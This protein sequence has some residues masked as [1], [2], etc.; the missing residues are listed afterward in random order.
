M[1]K[2][3]ATALLTIGLLAGHTIVGGSPAR[4]AMSD[5]PPK[6]FCLWEHINYGGRIVMMSATPRSS[7]GSFN[8][9]A[10]SWQNRS[11]RKVCVYQDINFDGPMI[12][13]YW[14]FAQ[15]DLRSPERFNDMISSF[16]FC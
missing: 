16:R 6:N 14:G 7:L 15:P 2:A 3:I 11:D 8:D 5:C 1:R 9:K 13:F 12:G 10:S 4:A